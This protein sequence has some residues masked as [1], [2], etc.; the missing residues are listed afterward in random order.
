MRHL[1][2]S[3]LILFLF[4]AAALA[5]G[6]ASY[7]PLQIEP[8]VK[9]EAIVAPHFTESYYYFDREHTLYFVMRSR[10][11]DKVAGKTVEQFASIRVFWRPVGGRTT[12]DHTALNATYRYVLMTADS[13]GMYEGAG[14]VRL[15]GKDGVHKMYARLMDGDLRLTEAS[16]KFVDTLGR[17]RVRGNFH[18]TFDDAKALDMLLAE[19]REFFARSLKVVVPPNTTSTSRPSEVDF[20]TTSSLFP[21]TAPSTE[22]ATQTAVPA[23]QP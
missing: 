4:L 2:I 10:T 18:A 22:P 8:A 17:S 13:V 14:F 15:W 11:F 16:A 12:M 23:T 19:Q 6:C 21:E 7:R 9:K 3:V 20:P 5:G 1:K